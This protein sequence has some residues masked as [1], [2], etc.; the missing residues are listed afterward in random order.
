MQQV[1]L[2]WCAKKIE[3]KA[4]ARKVFHV[5]EYHSI[6]PV[7]SQP[8]FNLD[9]KSRWGHL[10]SGRFLAHFLG[11]ENCYLAARKGDGVDV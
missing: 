6:H 2:R 11:E 3:V 1:R 4:K 5:G 9:L 8:Q 7:A 10:C